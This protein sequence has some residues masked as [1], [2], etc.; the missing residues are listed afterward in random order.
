MAADEVLS[1][2]DLGGKDPVDVVG[3]LGEFV[4]GPA[5]GALVARAELEAQSTPTVGQVPVH[6]VTGPGTEVPCPHLSAQL[7]LIEKALHALLDEGVVG[8]RL[9]DNSRERHVD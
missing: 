2:W 5:P 3:V 7:P 9:V 4:F 6:R 1:D 8:T